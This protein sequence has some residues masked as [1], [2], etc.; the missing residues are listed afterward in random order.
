MPL[1]LTK[2]LALPNEAGLSWKRN[3]LPESGGMGLMVTV[4]RELSTPP[5]PIQTRLYTSEPAESGQKVSTVTM[6]AR[7]S[8]N[9][10]DAGAQLLS[11]LVERRQRGLNVKLSPTINTAESGLT[12]RIAFGFSTGDGSTTPLSLLQLTRVRAKT[13]TQKNIRARD[14][15][16]PR[17]S[18]SQRAC[19]RCN[20]ST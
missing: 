12:E 5:L 13:H 11:I 19:I 17:R 4:I 6:S 1:F 7:P 8:P 20:Y 14:M 3:T 16:P 2:K 15:I 18:L 10:G 9:R